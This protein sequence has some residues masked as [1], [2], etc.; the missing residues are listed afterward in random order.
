MSIAEGMDVERVRQIADSLGRSGDQ[1]REVQGAGS[2]SM[3]V[4]A[5]T[6]EG[7]DV[8]HFADRWGTSAGQLEAAAQALRDAHAELLRQADSQEDAS[9]GSGGSGG[10]GLP[11]S[12]DELFDDPFG[13]GDDGGGGWGLPDPFGALDDA[14]D[15]VSDRGEDAWEWA[16]ETASDGL[17]W[18]GDRFDDLGEWVGDRAEGAWGAI[19]DVWQDEVVARWDAGLAALERLGP[20]ITNVA[21]QLTQIFTEGRWPRFH[22]VAASAILLLGRAGGLVANVIT[23]EDH[24]IFESGEGTVISEIDVPADPTQPGR[25]PTDLNSLMD[26]VSD[27]YDRDRSGDDT[28]PSNRHIRVTEVTQPDGS[29]AYIVMVPG[30]NGLFDVPGSITG[31]DEPFDNTSNLE[32]QAG[33]RSASME[34]VMAAMGE[35]GIPPDAPVML[36][37]HSQGGMVTAELTQ[38]PAFM[39]AYN[40][41]HMITQG[42]PNDSRTIPGSV[43]T[44]A[45]EHTNDPVPMVDLGDAYLGPPAVVPLPGPLPPIVLPATP[46]PNFDPALAGSGLHVTQA[47]IDPEP[48]V[49]INGADTSSAHHYDNYADSVAREIAAGNP[50]FTEYASSAGMDVFLTDDP[51]Q[52]QITEYGAGRE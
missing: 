39:S 1:L 20:S 32:L 43:Q 49:T 18:V 3:R 46:I 25:V 16:T 38:D 6:W 41:T 11:E 23:G 12:V 50:A 2:A 17:D 44:L 51:S 5:G 37:G 29:S 8:E 19:T 30:T 28:D 27:T 10:G 21:S 31:G 34:A 22:E 42:S 7:T 9:G 45:I 40:V 4:L 13:D 33:Q 15:W 35:A 14:W 47:R 48:G 26:M 36:M 52:V 24:R